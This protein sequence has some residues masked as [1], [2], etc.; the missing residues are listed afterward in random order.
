MINAQQLKV[1]ENE[2]HNKT[3][4]ELKASTVAQN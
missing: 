2:G 1:D 4:F 3:F